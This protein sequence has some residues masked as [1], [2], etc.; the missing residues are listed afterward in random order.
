[1]YKNH[2]QDLYT[3]PKEQVGVWNCSY[4]D[5]S[6]LGVAKVEKNKLLEKRKLSNL[7]FLG[8]VKSTFFLLHM[9]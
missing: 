6:G 2:I 1:M 3:L 9:I 5:G 8:P 7:G 4:K